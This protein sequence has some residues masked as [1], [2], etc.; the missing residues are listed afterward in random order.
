MTTIATLKF[1]LKICDHGCS[2]YPQLFV[3]P[4]V[5]INYYGYSKGAIILA[6]QRCLS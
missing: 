6:W 3:I 2:C 4:K 1:F 5:T